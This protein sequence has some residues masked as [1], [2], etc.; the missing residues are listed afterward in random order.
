MIYLNSKYLSKALG[1]NLSKWKRWSREF[2]DPDP[3]GGYQSGYPR[4]F[5]TKDAFRVYLGGYLVADLKF[6]IPETRQILSD[7][8]VWLKKKRMYSL[9]VQ[10][11][12]P[13]T[14]S[15][16]IYIYRLDQ[17]KFGYAVRRIANQPFQTD[18]GLWQEHFEIEWIGI[19]KMLTAMDEFTHAR[20]VYI[21]TLYKKFLSRVNS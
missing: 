8:H 1:I 5:S 15:H 16:H 13:T 12:K 17:G 7:L 3:L 6:S 20:V 11:I 9:P 21:N 10:A 19:P 14:E 2:L 4:Q 18:G